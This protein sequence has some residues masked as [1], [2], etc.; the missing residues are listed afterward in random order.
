MAFRP[1]TNRMIPLVAMAVVFGL[2]VNALILSGLVATKTTRSIQSLD[3]LGQS[4]IVVQQQQQEQHAQQ[5]YNK[6]S[7]NSI[8]IDTT[9]VPHQLQYQHDKL[10]FVHI[11]KTAGETLKH[12]LRVTCTAPRR[13]AVKRNNC[14]KEWQTPTARTNDTNLTTSTTTTTVNGGVAVRHESEISQR[15]VAYM[16]CNLLQPSSRGGI[17]ATIHDQ[18]TTHLFCI[19]SPVD[20]IISWFRYI[21]PNAC[22]G[23]TRHGDTTAACVYKR[24]MV[25]QNNTLVTTFANCFPTLGH[26]LDSL[27]RGPSTSSSSSSSS[28][29]TT[30]AASAAVASNNNIS[31]EVCAQTAHAILQ[32]TST[33]V[34]VMG[35]SYFNY[36]V[37]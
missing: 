1:R 9:S 11:G 20:R 34:R 33:D 37:R 8:S 31:I 3:H 29:P 25:H 30:T 15:T 19:R 2:I 10:M 4:V 14:Y 26:F 22:R 13:N 28:P 12:H 18:I 36:Y 27:G 24:R 21:H 16:H 35:H 5:L 23:S 17:N 7:S 32:A 6:N